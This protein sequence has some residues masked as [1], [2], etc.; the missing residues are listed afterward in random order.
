MLFRVPVPGPF[1]GVVDFMYDGADLPG[2]ANIEYFQNGKPIS[3]KLYPPY[4]FSF[5]SRLEA[6]G[7]NH[8]KAVAYDTNGNVVDQQDL[9]VWFGNT[10]G[11][12]ASTVGGVDVGQQS[13]SGT[14]DWTVSVTPPTDTRYGLQAVLFY[15]DGLHQPPNAA[16]YPYSQIPQSAVHS[17]NTTLWTNGT[18]ELSAY[19]V[20]RWN[21]YSPPYGE[22]PTIRLQ[23]TILTEFNNGHVTCLLRPRWRELRMHPGET[24]NLGMMLTYTDGVGNEPVATISVVSDYPAV[25]TCDTTGEVTAISNGATAL[26]IAAEG[27]TTVVYVKV[28]DFVGLP[29]F[30][31]NGNIRTTY[32]PYKSLFVRSLF[33][34]DYWTLKNNATLIPEMWAANINVLESAFYLNPIDN[35]SLTTYTLWKNAFDTEWGQILAQITASGFGLLLMGD[36]ICR[37]WSE[38]NNSLNGSYSTQAIQYAFSQA[39]LLGVT[40]G[41]EMIDEVNL[42]WGNTPT[43]T[44]GRWAPLPNSAFSDLMTIINGVTQR[45]KIT[46]PCISGTDIPTIANWM[47]NPSF[48]DYA[49]TYWSNSEGDNLYL[50]SASLPQLYYSGFHA[51][52][53]K[54]SRAVPPSFPRMMEVSVLGPFYQKIVSGTEFSYGDIMEGS[55]GRGILPMQVAAQIMYGAAAGLTGVRLYSYDSAGWKSNRAGAAGSDALQTGMDPVSIG[56]DRW[57]AMSTSFAFVKDLEPYILQ[58]PI[59]PLDLG[60]LVYTAARQTPTARVFVAINMSEVPTLLQPDLTPYTYTTTETHTV[61]RRRLVGPPVRSIYDTV[62]DTGSDSVT[63]N[64]GESVVWIFT[65]P[66]PPLPYVPQTLVERGNMFGWNNSVSTGDFFGLHVP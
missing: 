42:A 52:F 40:L 62:P 37:S 10:G 12:I 50:A 48:S 47:G 49:T 51:A 26:T 57:Q 54:G 41:V 11:T 4:N 34:L 43:P 53:E 61:E 25:A 29:H 9:P 65:P 14:V 30:D 6:D 8:I 15:V 19:A 5:D 59:S 20:Y 7:P 45:P 33:T 28:K 1:V 58:D 46:W 24:V 27:Q 44:D 3:G 63:L 17:L 18:H 66:P 55:C 56:V 35:P 36:A 39:V 23:A 64:S 32:E 31:W 38:L 13:L 2:V 16:W 21:N 22:Q 60:L